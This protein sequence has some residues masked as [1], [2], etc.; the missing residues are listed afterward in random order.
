MYASVISMMMNIILNYLFIFRFG[1]IAA[2]YTTLFCYLMQAILDYY[3]MRKAVKFYIFNQKKISI[4]SFCILLI[5]VIGSII[6]KYILFRYFAMLFIII[7]CF[8]NRKY[9]ISI[10]EILRKGEKKNEAN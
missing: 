1:Y 9:I 2:G 7:L 4:I 3:A 5:S 8:Y 10:F 6:Y